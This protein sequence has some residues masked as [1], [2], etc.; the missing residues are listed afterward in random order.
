MLAVSDLSARAG[1]FS[2]EG[3]TLALEKREYFV[4]VG[5]TGSGKTTF[6][7]CLAGLHPVSSGGIFLG[8][9]EITRRDPADRNIGFLPQDYRLFPHLDVRGNIAFGVSV[10][11]TPRGEREER[12]ERLAGVLRIAHLLN[13]D[14]GTLSGGEMQ[15]VAL[16][17]AL[18][19]HPEAILLDEPFSAID[20]GMRVRLWF[21]IKEILHALDVAVVHVTHNLDEASAIAD[22]I[23]VLIDGRLEQVGPR[24]EVLLR[25]ATERV[26]RYLG[27]RN[28]FE[29]E[30][31]RA[32]GG[33]MTVRCGP[34]DL[35][36]P[37][38]APPGRRLSLCV[39]PQDIKV[40]KP[41][42]P[43][44][45]ELRDNLFEGEVVSAYFCND[46]CTVTVSAGAEFEMRFPSYIYRRHDLAKGKRI[47]IGL[48][49]SAITIFPAASPRNG[50]GP[51]G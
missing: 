7:R 41:G 39:R 27:I 28:I 18:I 37:G 46:F 34:I 43:L 15:R 24:D 3:M 29:G 13:R 49:R 8:G 14:T 33:K 16:A 51:P 45:E 31:A 17:R 32:G 25:P 48:R 21:E 2:L 19:V 22:R 38:D 20:P 44:R 11:G 4:L 6:I 10:R 40:I 26:A 36:V 50:H 1:E 23:G 42:Q 30:V 47:T 35:T 12:L 9:R 5:P